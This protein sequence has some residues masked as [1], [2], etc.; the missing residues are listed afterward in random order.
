MERPTSSD[1]QFQNVYIY[2]KLNYNFENDDLTVKSINITSPSAFTGD[3]TFSGDTLNVTNAI[4]VSGIST[5]KDNIEFHGTNGISSITFDK[6]QNSLKFLD[7]SKAIFGTGDDLQIY[8]TNELKDQT[9]SNGDSVCDNRTSLIK[10][11]GSGGLIF[12]SNGGDGPGAYQFF[13]QG[14]R[15]MLK[16]HGGNNARTVL[17]HDGNER[18]VTTSSGIT[19]TGSLSVSGTISGSGLLPSGVILLWSGAADAIPSGFVLCDGNNSTPNLSGKFI[20]GYSAS[21]GDYDVN[22][23]GGA[24]SVTLTLNQIPAHTHTYERTDVGIDV[25]DRPW[26]ASN[27][28]CDMTNQNTSSAGGGQAHENRPPFYALCYIMK[29]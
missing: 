19:V 27:N 11:K 9:D 28:D 16:M 29:T 18:L 7:E 24:E 2:G 23:T 13:D 3:V 10:E 26:P 8:H 6:S 21:N 20:V 17:Y 22:D 4:N 12:K 5:F 25:S 14:W 1:N 15:P